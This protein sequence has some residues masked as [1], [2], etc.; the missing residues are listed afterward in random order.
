MTNSVI[1]FADATD[2]YL[3][4]FSKI[5]YCTSQLKNAWVHMMRLLWRSI[6]EMNKTNLNYESQVKG[7]RQTLVFFTTMKVV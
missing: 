6:K 2:K 3:E 4:Y 7:F 5:K 1:K